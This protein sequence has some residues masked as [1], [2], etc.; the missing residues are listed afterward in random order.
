MAGVVNEHISPREA[1]RAATHVV[2]V[3]REAGHAAYFAGGC[4][5]DELLGLHPSDYDVAT[6]ARP[7]QIRKL[8]PRTAAV[9]AAFGVMLVH[10]DERQLAA[11]APVTVEVA[12]FRSDGSYTDA[13][14]PDKVHFSTDTEDAARRDFTINALFLDPLAE[15]EAGRDVEDGGRVI[16]YVG[17]REDLAKQVVRAVGDPEARLAEDHLRALRAVRFAARLGFAI[18]PGTAA[19]IRRH[20]AELRGVSRERIGDELRRMMAHP[21]RDR[22]VA[23]LREL[24]L[25]TPALGL[26]AGAAAAVGSGTPRLSGLGRAG[27]AE[28]GVPSITRLGWT[29]KPPFGACLAAWWLD[30]V[31]ESAAIG[32]EAIRAA[33]SGL[34]SAL[35]LSNAE[36]EDLGGVLRTYAAVAGLGGEGGRESGGADQR[37][38]EG[39]P[40]SLRR[41]V[42][43]AGGGRAF[44]WACAVLWAVD[45]GRAGAV[46][47]EAAALAA[48]SIGLAPT[49]WVLG[50]DLIA[51]GMKPGPSFKRILD[52]VYDAQLEGK[53]TTPEAGRELARR[54]GV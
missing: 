11:S 7:E 41:R 54:L 19:A 23:W 40:V 49:P 50:D 25:E 38:W 36:T 53:I 12:T 46:A 39:M 2:R 27:E 15:G 37:G 14:R 24:N 47:E 45:P 5:R 31:G 1:R 18:E 8:F 44:A 13:R 16:D 9:G 26:A 4:V 6:S 30:G 42:A 10:V 32:E 3:L 28:G 22:A 34:R 20:A 35:C 29:P 48:D 52:E 21:A 51:M 17:G 33:V 43:G